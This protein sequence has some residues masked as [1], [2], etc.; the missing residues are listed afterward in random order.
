MSNKYTPLAEMVICT[1]SANSTSTLSRTMSA[2]VPPP[3]NSLGLIDRQTARPAYAVLVRGAWSRGRV[4][5]RNVIV[6]DE[7]ECWLE[8]SWRRYSGWKVDCILNA[9]VAS[10][11]LMRW[12][13]GS[14]C[15][16]RRRVVAI[17]K[18]CKS[19]VLCTQCTEYYQDTVTI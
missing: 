2:P 14:Q 17:N 12:V 1:R 18:Y 3:K 6:I 15:N 16:R 11:K 4:E 10:L 7:P 8:I 5:K 9:R 19:L 13:I